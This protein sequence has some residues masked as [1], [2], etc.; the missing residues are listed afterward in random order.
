MAKE[1][2]TT[3]VTKKDLQ[4]IKKELLK[5]QTAPPLH[6]LATKLA[7]EKNASQLNQAVKQYNPDCTYEPGDL[8]CKDYD[9]QL[10]VSSKGTEAFKGKV[11]LKVINKK[12]YESYNCEMLG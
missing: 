3:S 1:N 8:I 4:F 9:E 10:T 11:V 12:S 6:E 7:F 5:E 2:E